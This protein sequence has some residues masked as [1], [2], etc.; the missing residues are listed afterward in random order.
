[1]FAG[2]KANAQSS[3][4]QNVNLSFTNIVEILFTGTG[5]T[6]GASVT[7]PFTSPGDY[8]D[9]VESSEYRLRVR[10]NKNFNVTARTNSANFT[11]S[12]TASPAPVMPVSGKLLLK[13]SEN[14]T[15][16]ST[17]S[18][19]S[20]FGTLTSSNQNLVTGGSKGNNQTFSVQYKGVPGFGYPAGDYSVNVVYTVTQQ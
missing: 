5:G 20:N 13:V 8:T 3:A 4:T 10:S 12:G 16:G 18:G 1:M 11:Y 9:G 19:F 7:M 6:S 2:L 14:N 17:A 15:G